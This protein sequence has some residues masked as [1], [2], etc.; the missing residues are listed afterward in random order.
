VPEQQ[1]IKNGKKKN[2][3]QNLLCRCCGKQFL[4]DYRKKGATPA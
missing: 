2:G 1:D 4:S 3:V